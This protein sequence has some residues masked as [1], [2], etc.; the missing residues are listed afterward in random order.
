MGDRNCETKASLL[1]LRKL[2]SKG[3]D[4]NVLARREE[5]DIPGRF[6]G[7]HLQVRL[8]WW[9]GA[10][11]HQA[12]PYRFIVHPRGKNRDLRGK[13]RSNLASL[14]SNNPKMGERRR[15]GVIATG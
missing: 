10:R 14:Y 12:G 6:K 5:E 13:K 2:G 9:N 8:P 15:G 11:Q 4:P 3:L 7:Q 1:Y